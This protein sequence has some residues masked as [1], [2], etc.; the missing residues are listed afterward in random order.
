MDHYKV[1][2]LTKNA[3]KSEIKDAFRKLALKFHPDRHCQSPKPIRDDAARQFKH[4]SEAYH[5]LT[6]DRK[7]AEYNLRST[8]RR[9]T[10]GQTQTHY[11]SHRHSRADSKLGL[12]FD[13][14]IKFLTTRAFLL[15]LAFAC[16]LFGGAVVVERS[17]DALW[18]MQNS[19]KSFEETMEAMDNHRKQKEKS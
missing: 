14:A 17:A 7:R 13:V 15:N 5:L 12:D 4:I 8:P 19:G 2:G 1:L 3:S 9:P 6:D 11:Y 18:K 10:H 16:F